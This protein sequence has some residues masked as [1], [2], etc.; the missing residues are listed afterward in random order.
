MRAKGVV[1]VVMVV[2]SMGG[3]EKA[4]SGGT[5][6]GLRVLEPVRGAQPLGTTLPSRVGQAKFQ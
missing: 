2:M 1:I 5:E 4:P 6:G 3:N